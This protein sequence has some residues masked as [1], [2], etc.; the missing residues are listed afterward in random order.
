MARDVRGGGGGFAAVTERLRQGAA[1]YEGMAGELLAEGERL[2]E[3]FSGAAGPAGNPGVA[4]PLL[5]SAGAFAEFA[6][7]LAGICRPRSG[8]GKP[9]ATQRGTVRRQLRRATHVPDPRRP[10]GRAPTAGAV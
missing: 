9:L 3:V 4:G 6:A 2:H 1:T 7:T 8:C 5:T 10:R